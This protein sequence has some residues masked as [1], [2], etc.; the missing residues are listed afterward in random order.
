MFDCF[1]DF[2]SGD[3]PL[4]IWLESRIIPLLTGGPAR[5]RERSVRENRVALLTVFL[6][7]NSFES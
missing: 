5:E 7:L 4:Y 2:K 1:L 3:I 6:E